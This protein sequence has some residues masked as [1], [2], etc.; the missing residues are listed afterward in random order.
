ERDVVLALRAQDLADLVEQGV[1]R[2][3]DA[4]LAELAEPGQIATDLRGVDVRVLR[5]LLRGDPVLPHLSRLC[6]D[7]QVA[8]QPRCDS[9]R[10]PLRQTRLL[11]HPVPERRRLCLRVPTRGR[12]NRQRTRAASASGV[13][14]KVNAGSPS[15]STTGIRSR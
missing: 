10:H 4:A 11:A 6:E 2:V 1:D 14:K 13:T 12:R 15:I 7:L 3:A 8:A 9:D 5:D